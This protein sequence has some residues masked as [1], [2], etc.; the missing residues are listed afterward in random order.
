MPCRDDAERAR[1]L[2][3]ERLDVLVALGLAG[4]INMAMLAVAA[5]LFHNPAHAQISTLQQA[6]AGFASWPAGSPPWPSP[7]PC[8][9]PG[10]PPQAWGP[11]PAR[12]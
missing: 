8:S 1:V 11:T 12:W 7:S 10:P 9:P 5:K 2:R 4:V 6:H 3:F